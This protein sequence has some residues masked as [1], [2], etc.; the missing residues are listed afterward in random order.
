MRDPRIGIIGAGALSTRRI[1]PY[2]GAA[3]AQLVG[4]CDLDREKAERNARRFGGR[5]YTDLESMLEAERPDA[6][7]IC[8]GPAAHA[9]LA[10]VVMRRGIPVYTEKPPAPTAPASHEV[11][12]LSRE[13]GVLRTTAFTKRYNVSYSR[14]R[15]RIAQFH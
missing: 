12:R 7:M 11:A 5:V 4:V 14:S 13:T 8:I 1:Y 6:V 10:P 9:A 15:E 3:G 2:I